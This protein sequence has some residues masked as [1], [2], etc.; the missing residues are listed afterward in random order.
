MSKRTCTPTLLRTSISTHLHAYVVNSSVR[1]DPSMFPSLHLGIH[2]SWDA[3]QFADSNCKPIVTKSYEQNLRWSTSRPSYLQTY[4]PPSFDD[5]MTRYH[6]VHTWTY[7]ATYLRT[8]ILRCHH[9]HTW[10]WIPTVQTYLHACTKWTPQ[11]IHTYSIVTPQSFFIF[12][13]RSV[14]LDSL[15]LEL[16]C[17]WSCI[18]V[19]CILMVTLAECFRIFGM[20]ALVNDISSEHHSDSVD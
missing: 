4:I 19:H 8:Y 15:I 14:D 5:S 18:R 11:Y 3:F 17:T 9:N 16:G 7:M 12:H 10:E 2:T 6:H 1:V 13:L 20:F